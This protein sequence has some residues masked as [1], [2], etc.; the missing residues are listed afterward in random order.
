M[1][2]T[3]AIQQFLLNQENA[4]P[5]AKF[6]SGD[7]EVQVNVIPGKVVQATGIGK[8]N[9]I[10]TD[11]NE[12]WKPFRIPWRAND[13]PIYTDGPQHFDLNK[14]AQAIGMSG[15]DW[16][17]QK[18]IWVGFD[19]DSMINHSK[20]LSNEELEKIFA[21]LCEIDWVTIYTSTSGLGYH[22]YIFIDNSPTIANHTDHAAFARSIL[23]KLS[24][25]CSFD[26][27]DKVDVCGGILW[28]WKR[29]AETGFKLI[30][31]GSKLDASKIYDWTDHRDATKLR[32]KRK[33]RI[34]EPAWESLNQSIRRLELDDD[35]IK[36]IKWLDQNNKLH[37]WDADHWMLICH[38]FDLKQAHEELNFIGIYNTISTGKDSG[39]D[40]NCFCFP[41]ANGSWVIRRH[42]IGCKEHKTWRT[43][44]SGWTYCFYNRLPNLDIGCNLY[45]IP[46]KS[47]SWNYKKLD[48][49][50]KTLGLF[51]ID[52]QFPDGYGNRTGTIKDVGHNRI[53]VT[54]NAHDDDIEIDGWFKKG[55]EWRRV[56]D[57]PVQS[58]EDFSVDHIVRHVI[59]NEKDAG[60]YAFSRDCWIYEPKSNITDLLVSKGI[61]PRSVS[62]LLGKSI[63]ESWRLTT[64]PFR[65]EYPGNRQW[66][67]N[68][69][70]LI[71]A[72]P[73]DHPHW[74]LILSHIGSSLKC[75]EN[76]WCVENG[77]L[78]G[79][80]YLQIWLAALVQYP[81]EPLPYLFLYGPQDSGK[82]ILHE[83]I[84][85]LFI[86]GSCR[87]DI[88]IT[89]SSAFNAEIEGAVLCVIEE[90]NLQTN[91]SAY[92]RI[93]D[94]VTSK[95]ITIH[96]KG[97]TPYTVPNVSHWIQCSN[98]PSF[99]PIFA[100]DTRICVLYV[101]PIENQIP[102]QKLLA[103]LQ[104]EA[105]AFLSTI[106]NIELPDPIDRLRIPII[107]T[108]AKILQAELNKGY[109]EIFCEENLHSVPGQVLLFSDFCER[110]R[111]WLPISEKAY[112]TDRRIVTRFP[113]E[114]VRG[115]MGGDNKT[116]IANISFDPGAKIGRRIIYE[117]G[118][119][120]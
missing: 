25:L 81:L 110:F 52:F 88:A 13:Q 12:T 49:L 89:S 113:Q 5:V 82:S 41:L 37:W 101:G 80:A 35:H 1:N 36:L 28:V 117:K 55:R 119:L 97:Q 74:D 103:S 38:T 17:S 54:F 98:D 47:D 50:A 24:G 23:S 102:K 64:L 75:E 15:W 108:D 106:L 85:L 104:T 115:K 9:Q 94:W 8:K 118:R 70:Q 30:K 71:P 73:G 57:L 58:N 72:K 14:Y 114:Y 33:V 44:R 93:K 116:Y 31:D 16:A 39:H 27:S 26:L 86:R 40:Q 90:I 3:D 21:K 87:A 76:Q 32:G 79:L 4:S 59:S 95:T 91:K 6:Y 7:M 22:I 77:V 69:A 105:P 84:E 34:T 112:W 56:F 67:K 120:K 83:A 11:G 65:D 99:C 96:R 63:S 43:D 2:K 45:G 60:W 61:N 109:L 10:F 62:S 20:G 68:A 78:T 53:L 107:E 92:E 111:D 46:D 66:N 18:S 19:F 51:G 100:G 29:N 48:D 42:T